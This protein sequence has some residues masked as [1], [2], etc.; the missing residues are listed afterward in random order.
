MQRLNP[1]SASWEIYSNL[2][3]RAPM[4]ARADGRGFK[5]VLE[6]SKKPYD[7]DFA[8][9][10]AEASACFF[11]ESGLMPS[12]AFTFS[13]EISLVFLEAP[14]AGR[15]EKIDSL[16]AGFLS[17]VISLQLARPV[18][19]DCRTIPLC[20]DEIEVYLAERQDETWRNHVFSYGFYMLAEEGLSKALA[21]ERLRGMKEHEI[22][23]LVYQKGVNL[24]QTPAWERRGVMIC[25]KDGLVV[26]DWELPLFSSKEGKALLVE[27][28]ETARIGSK[29]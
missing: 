3:A 29:G 22:H 15:V 10:M 17:S 23:E 13:D 26:Q 21:M 16:I 6:A 14:F 25:R 28:I 9:V 5:K 18:S 19:M 11:R 1:K 12:L 24:A 4:V 7:I 8:K 20:Q 27:I 2:R